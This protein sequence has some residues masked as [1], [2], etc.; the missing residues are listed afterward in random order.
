MKLTKDDLSK[1]M[2][3]RPYCW[4]SYIEAVDVDNKHEIV[5]GEKNGN[6]KNQ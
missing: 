5:N 6:N 1:K 4:L 3:G 2:Y